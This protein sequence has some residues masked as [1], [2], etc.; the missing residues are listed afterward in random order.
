MR[1]FINFRKLILRTFYRQQQFEFPISAYL[2]VHS[3]I[4]KNTLFLQTNVA[5]MKVID[6]FFV[7]FHNGINYV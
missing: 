4:F 5:I 1:N 2:S 7:C 3:R 6:F